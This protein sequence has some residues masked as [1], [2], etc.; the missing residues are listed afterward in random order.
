VT[1]ALELRA[2]HFR[3][4][5]ITL[6]LR[7]KNAS[8]SGQQALLAAVR[9]LKLDYNIQNA[10][11]VKLLLGDGNSSKKTIQDLGQKL[12][13]LLEA[14]IRENVLVATLGPVR[15]MKDRLRSA[16]TIG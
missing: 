14:G 6:L 9:G 4:A 12:N 8:F 11:I 7:R 13:E 10:S 5:D 2:M 16:N 1:T 3:N 15:D